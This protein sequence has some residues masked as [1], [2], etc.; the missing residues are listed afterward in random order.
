[1]AE[2]IKGKI[3]EYYKLKKQYESKYE[4]AKKKIL[5]DEN[6]T[7]KEK[8]VR[9]RQIKEL[10]Y[11]C[12]KPGGSLFLN[13]GKTLRI[14]CGNK[15]NPCK[16]NFEV[17]KDGLYFNSPTISKELSDS[18][19]KAKDSLIISKLEFLFSYISEDK[20]IEGLQKFKEIYDT[21]QEVLDYVN[22]VI[23]NATDNKDKE[24]DIKDKEVELYVQVQ[25]FKQLLNQY[26]EEGK[27]GYLD[28]ALEIY[29][30]KIIPIAESLRNVKYVD[31]TIEYNDSDD[32]YHLIQNPFNLK[33]LE[34]ALDI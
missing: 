14:T 5:K 25:E 34:V 12:K 33:T 19:E 8:Q 4:K 15:E 23:I 20:V 1:M 30:Q 6:L 31:N 18:I 28:D 27:Q 10:C 9:I 21:Q 22:N 32:T 16:L 3:D 26:K 11:N 7:I 17:S 24:R 29:S 13:D 2:S